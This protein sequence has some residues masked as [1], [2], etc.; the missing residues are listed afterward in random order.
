MKST[1]LL[2]KKFLIWHSR[3]PIFGEDT[4][5]NLH[6]T[7]ALLAAAGVSAGRST[8]SWSALVCLHANEI[9]HNARR[10]T[11]GLPI[12]LCTPHAAF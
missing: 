7:F 5:S 10:Y 2:W 4:V 6:S 11:A 1:F 3:T 9:P 8:K 12:L